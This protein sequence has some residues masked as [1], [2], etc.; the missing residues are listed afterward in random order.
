MP[1]SVKSATVQS[2]LAN[3]STTQLRTVTIGTHAVAITTP[4]PSPPDWRDVWIYFL[5]VD[6]FNNPI[7]PPK[8]TPF[9]GEYGTFQGGTFNG[10]REQLD[11]LQELG[12]GA[13]WLSPVVK[14]CQYEDTTYHGYGFQDF[15]Q[16]E[17]RFASDPQAAKLNSQLAEDE[18]R[19]LIDAAHARNI[20]VIFDIVLNHVGNVFGYNLTGNPN[21]AEAPGRST[22]YP[23]NWH[24]ANGQPAF[25]DFSSGVPVDDDGAVWPVELQQN[26]F[27]RR[28]GLGGEEGG[29]FSSLKEFVTDFNESVA[30]SQSFPVRDTLILAYQ[31]LIAKYDIDGYRIDTLK[32]IEADFARI[33][34]NAMREFSLSIGK[35]NFFTF[36]EVYDEEE[37]INQ[38]IGRT[39][40]LTNE[41][42]GVDAALD[43]PLF[44]RLPSV[45]KGLSAPSVVKDMYLHRK[46]VESDILSTHGDAT[47]FFVTFLDNHDMRQRYYFSD[48]TNP[49]RFDNQVTLG[50]A[51]LFAL[52]GIPCVYYGTEQGLHGNGNSDAAV[53]EALWGKGSGAF[54]ATH[55]FYEAIKQIS[56]VRAT[57]PALRYGRQYFRPLSGDGVN[58][59]ISPFSPG[60]LAF[61]RILNDQEVIVVANTQTGGGFDGEV[62][63]DAVLN[64]ELT[65]YTILYS[66]SDQPQPPGIASTKTS[67][68]VTIYEE[69]GSVT[70]GPARVVRVRLHPMEV[71]ILRCQK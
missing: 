30:I 20:Y 46:L 60:V 24:D 65:T 34:A 38:F 16:V 35:K 27:F 47:N 43:F 26:E 25:A 18:L 57:Q 58:F 10:I 52:Q 37:K 48:S 12:V 41:P 55:P 51:C 69:R 19:G 36:G 62:I 2:V 66:N 70:K 63:V 13:I 23:I 44:F 7:A 14:N 39:T 71:Q 42:I 49:N 15:L 40:N 54:D 64:P 33:F 45:T 53:R 3:A 4:F 11:Y 32:Y 21:S 9:N 56:L 5:L 28:K 17:P 50:L 8:H 67:G 59:G 31:Y 61:S 29:D 6:R 68:G 1:T 22:V